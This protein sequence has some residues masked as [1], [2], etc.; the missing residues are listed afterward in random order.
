MKYKKNIIY[1]QVLK[2]WLEIFDFWDDQ[3]ILRINTNP[4]SSKIYTFTFKKASKSL[5]LVEISW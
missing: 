2:F 5:H 1:F 3:K 4:F